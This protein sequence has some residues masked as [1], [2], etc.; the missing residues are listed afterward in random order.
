MKKV[1]QETINKRKATIAAKKNKKETKNV[2][3]KGL[4]ATTTFKDDK[5]LLK[6]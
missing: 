5:N 4:K 2:V 3:N 6:T 1:S